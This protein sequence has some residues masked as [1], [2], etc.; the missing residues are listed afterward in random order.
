M[1]YPA[2]VMKSI[3]DVKA[4][5]IDDRRYEQAK[6]GMRS[7]QVIIERLFL[8]IY[9]PKT[10]VATELHTDKLNPAE[11]TTLADLL[12]KAQIGSRPFDA[13]EPSDRH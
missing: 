9:N 5:T 12:R 7:P 6:S 11:R 13:V 1:S 2:Q 3:D 4:I 10:L 8:V